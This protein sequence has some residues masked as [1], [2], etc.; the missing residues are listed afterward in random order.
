MPSGR[1]TVVAAKGNDETSKVFY[2]ACWRL[3]LPDD[4]SRATWELW[5]GPI[6]LDDRCG[7]VN[8]LAMACEDEYAHGL[9]GK[10]YEYQFL[11]R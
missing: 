5:D 7:N 8:S 1:S 6:R 10:I 4:Y 3:G 11:T 9:H 2:I